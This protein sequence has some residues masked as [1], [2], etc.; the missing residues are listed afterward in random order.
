MKIAA[1]IRRALPPDAE[2]ISRVNSKMNQSTSA[3]EFFDAAMQC[4]MGAHS[5]PRGSVAVTCNNRLVVAA[6]YGGRAANERVPVWSL[7]KVITALCVASLIRKA[8]G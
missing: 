3:A 4:W 1:E 8:R 6:G 5:V 7:S 2:E